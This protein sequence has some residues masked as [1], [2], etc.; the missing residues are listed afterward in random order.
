MGINIVADT[1][2]WYAIADGKLDPK[3][4]K[5]KGKLCATPLSLIEIGSGVNDNTFTQRQKAVTAIILHADRFLQTK[6]NY[7]AQYWGY[8]GKPEID[9]IQGAVTI[10]KATSP[11]ELTDGF[12]DFEQKVVRKQDTPF[13]YE[14]KNQ[15]YNAFKQQIIELI[16][17]IHPDYITQTEKG[18]EHI[19]PLTDEIIIKIFDTEEF[20]M[21]GKHM[22]YE[23]MKMC[24]HKDYINCI[25]NIP[26][27]M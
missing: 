4:L 26:N 15:H 10:S 12:T 9:W 23:R 11:K 20:F 24:V 21:S 18:E 16:S 27:K 25:P 2:I 7:L 6:E 3:E 17:N 8:K 5:A 19:L 13:L 22:A 14:W 1:N